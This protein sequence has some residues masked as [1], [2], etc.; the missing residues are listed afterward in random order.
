MKYLYHVSIACF[1]Q[2]FALAAS[3]ADP[4]V[5]KTEDEL[6]AAI[7][8][9]NGSQVLT[10]AE[11]GEGLL[12]ALLLFARDGIFALMAV[13]AIGMFLFI[14]GRLLMARGNP[15]QFKKA[16]MSFV[17]AAIGIFV[18]AAAWALVKLIAGINI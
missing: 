17:Y 9:D 18:V 11:T 2:L 12:D 16:M 14:G 4:I 7:I 15:E 3:A 10:S 5:A 6:K 13:V 8:P 1:T